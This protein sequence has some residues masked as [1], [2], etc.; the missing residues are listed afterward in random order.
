MQDVYTLVYDAARPEL[1]LKD[2]SCRRTVGPGRADR[3]PRRLDLERPRARDRRSCSARTGR[4]SATR[5]A[6]TSR[7]AT[8]RARTRSTS[9][10]PRSTPGACAIGPAVYVAGRPRAAG[11]RDR[12]AGL[13][14]RGRGRSFEGETSTAQMKRSF[15]ELVAWLVRDNPVPPGQRPPDGHRASCRPTTSPCCPATSSRSTSRR[16]ARS[17][18]PVVLASTC[19]SERS[20]PMTETVDRGPGPQLR[21]RRVARAA[22]PARRTRSATRG[23]RPR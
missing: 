19:C 7:R 18:N 20:P 10:R 12:A 22:P 13:D 11:V 17:C 21:R 4:S 15:D 23:A 8:S 5:S 3:D 6:T 14:E 2:A 1:F 16:S 9:R